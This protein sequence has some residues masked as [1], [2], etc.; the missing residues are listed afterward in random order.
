MQ[1]IEKL[2]DYNYFTLK[3]PK[4]LQTP[5]LQY[6]NFF[7]DYVEATKGKNIIFDIKRDKEGLVL[8]TN[9]NIGLSLSDLSDYFQE[10]VSLVH[11]NPE[12]WMNYFEVERSALS[13]D[14]LRVKLERQI[15]SLKSDLSIA[16][17]EN[18][19]LAV[20]LGDKEAQNEF[21]KELSHS[22]SHKI[23]LLIKG[24]TPETLNKN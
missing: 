11:K 19:Y 13:A 15:N 3:I 9:G 14:I 24:R 17:L 10:Y 21:L 1:S 22:L 16:Q 20:Q 2:E 4:V 7:K 18:K 23:D 12:E 5:M 8:I 6:L